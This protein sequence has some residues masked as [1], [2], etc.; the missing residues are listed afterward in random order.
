M[1]RRVHAGSSW[2][3]DRLHRDK[4]WNYLHGDL[5]ARQWRRRQFGDDYDHHCR[6]RLG[7]GDF[8]S[9]GVVVLI[10]LLD[11]DIHAK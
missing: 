6:L 3:N 8:F 10:N 1:G 7:D 9:G 2:S 4:R 11:T 5:C